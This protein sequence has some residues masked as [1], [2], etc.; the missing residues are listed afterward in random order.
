MQTG[1]EAA[2]AA[3]VEDHV[4]H[5]EDNCEIADQESAAEESDSA[6]EF[7]HFEGQE[8]GS[9]CKGDPLGPGAALPEAIRF[10]EAE[11]GVGERDAGGGPESRVGDAVCKV[12]KA[13]RQAVIGADVQERQQTF[14]QQPGVLVKEYQGADPHQ[15]DEDSLKELKAGDCAQK[16]T[17]AAVVAIDGLSGLRHEFERDF[18]G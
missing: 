18:A 13:L 16:V 7:A 9:G 14:R 5:I 15:Y 2:F 4:E 6:K 11:S 8:Q 17:L 12:E 1:C 10:G 3:I